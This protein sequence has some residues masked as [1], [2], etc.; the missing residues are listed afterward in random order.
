[1]YLKIT[2]VDENDLGWWMYCGCMML[3]MNA[4]R[5]IDNSKYSVDI[6][7]FGKQI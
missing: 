4:K 7:I 6:C 3:Y 5:R 2:C 1:M